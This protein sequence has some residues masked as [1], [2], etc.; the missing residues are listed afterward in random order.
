[1]AHHL[2]PTSQL[3]AKQIKREHG[4][5]H[6]KTKDLE[7]TAKNHEDRIT[8]VE[9]AVKANAATAADVGGNAKVQAVNTSA[10][11]VRLDGMEK[12]VNARIGEIE[13]EG[14]A[15][16]K[17]LDGLQRDKQV[18]EEERKAT[19]TKDKALLKRIG[20]VEEGLRKYEKNLDLIGK[21]TDGT[22][23][24]TIKKQLE[25]LTKDVKG[26]GEKFKHLEQS[27]ASLETA[28]EAIVK[29]N[30]KLERRLKT[31]EAKVAEQEVRLSEKPTIAGAEEPSSPEETD[32]AR[33]KSHKWAGGGADRD[34]IKQGEDLF[35]IKRIP[36]P[37]APKSQSKTTVPKNPV[38]KPVKKTPIAKK[39]NPVPKAKTDGSSSRKSHKW[40]GGGADRDIIAQ[41]Y[42]QESKY[43]YDRVWTDATDVTPTVKSQASSKRYEGGKEV[44]RSGR[45]WFEVE[46][47]PTPEGEPAT[48][49]LESR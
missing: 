7:T 3:W 15:M 10:V 40:A 4:F 42:S 23:M 1:M 34:I 46:R 29:A 36:K 33:K 20:E 24:E 18:A 21:S 14:F 22:M 44:V 37:A 11:K 26:E 8:A 12:S 16:T 41:G 45:G 28:N 6:K 47:S 27:V 43:G 35:G 30:E 13:A 2:D 32:S 17:V 48:D 31:S 38:P 39:K 5:L 9:K 19:L 25:D 49:L